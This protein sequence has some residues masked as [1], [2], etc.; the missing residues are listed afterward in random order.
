MCLLNMIFAIDYSFCVRLHL[1][2][3]HP[4]NLSSLDQGIPGGTGVDGGI[5]HI[6]SFQ[7]PVV[8]RWIYKL[9][10]CIPNVSN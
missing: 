1:P 3:E 6:V 10:C 2:R 9:K 4:S 8:T 7:E 5:A